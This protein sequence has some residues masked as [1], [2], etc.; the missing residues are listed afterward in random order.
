[1]TR[2]HTVGRSDGAT[3]RPVRR[4]ALGLAL[5]LVALTGAACG[6]RAI[7]SVPT[8]PDAI[9]LLDV[10]GQA[11]LEAEKRET[12]EGETKRWEIV[13]NEGFFGDGEAEL[14]VQVLRDHGLPRPEEPTGEDGGLIPSDR[15]EKLREQ[16]RVRTD[17]ERQLRALPGVTLAIV[18]V[19][20]PQDPS[21][22]LNPYPATASVVINYRDQKPSFTEQQIQ[23]LVAGGVPNL[24]PENVRVTISPQ[25]LRPVPQR[26]LNTRRRNN[27][28]TAV[29][30]GLVTLLGFLLVVLLLQTRRQRAQLAELRDADNFEADNREED[31]GAGVDED[32]AT[33]AGV[34]QLPDTTTAGGAAAR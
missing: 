5:A 7:T 18:T 20:L 12:G 8:E 29:G 1:M 27:I 13:V 15:A 17:I 21:L 26:E 31:D 30:V 16:R 11:G 23:N 19:V 25:T 32:A 6:R 33:G 24:K 3:A 9:E 14:A 2:R 28:L 34:K 22:E 10:L 4:A